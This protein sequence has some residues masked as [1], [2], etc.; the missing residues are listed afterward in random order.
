MTFES[1]KQIADSMVK[2]SAKIDKTYEVGIDLL[3]FVE[4]YN[5]LFIFFGVKR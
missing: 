1:F 4:D 5:K 2:S 3:E